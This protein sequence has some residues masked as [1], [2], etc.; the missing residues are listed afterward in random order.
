M[1][2]YYFFFLIHSYHILVQPFLILDTIARIVTQ[3]Q[4][5]RSIIEILAARKTEQNIRKTMS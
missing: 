1:L 5:R 2:S 3:L 4:H